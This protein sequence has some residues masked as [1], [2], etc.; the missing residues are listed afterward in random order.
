M[1]TKYNIE[2]SINTNR[3]YPSDLYELTAK[4][5][6][7]AGLIGEKHV[8][9]FGR[10]YDGYDNSCEKFVHGYF[11]I[12]YVGDQLRTMREILDEARIKASGFD[13]MQQKVLDTGNKLVSLLEEHFPLV[14][15]PLNI[16]DSIPFISTMELNTA[17]GIQSTHA[18]VKYTEELKGVTYFW[19]PKK[20][21]YWYDFDTIIN[22][23]IDLELS[24]IKTILS[25]NGLFSLFDLV[26]FKLFTKRLYCKALEDPD[27]IERIPW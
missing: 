19:K 1:P 2:L 12:F 13:E 4:Q 23:S 25:R 11:D 21:R 24:S 14:S 17:C 8:N 6:N 27:S 10:L 22:Y 20:D 9:H 15:L 7:A 5:F 3:G 16:Y 18:H 26:L